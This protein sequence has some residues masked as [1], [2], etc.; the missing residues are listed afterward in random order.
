MLARCMV[1]LL[2]YIRILHE[3]EDIEVL[4]GASRR[5][6]APRLAPKNIK[7]VVKRITHHVH[8][9]LVVATCTYGI[10]VNW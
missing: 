3:N 1:S 7:A 9:H 5:R 4:Y 2:D 6:N 8:T 10:R